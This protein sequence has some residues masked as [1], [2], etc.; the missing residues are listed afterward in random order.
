[1]NLAMRPHDAFRE[2][3]NDFLSVSAFAEWHGMEE[4]EARALIEEGRKI[5]HETK[6]IAIDA[7]DAFF[8]SIME[9]IDPTNKFKLKGKVSYF[10][11]GADE[12]EKLHEIAGK[13][14]MILK[15]SWV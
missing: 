4:E 10:F 13:V 9:A 11:D 8:A 3:F 7:T 14:A 5:E 2:W 6:M 1:M 15:R 12:I